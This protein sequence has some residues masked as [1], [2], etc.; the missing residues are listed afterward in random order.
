MMALSF[1]TYFKF[2][3]PNLQLK[4]LHTH[5][6][7]I[8]FRTHAFYFSTHGFRLGVRLDPKSL[9]TPIVATRACSDSAPSDIGSLTSSLSKSGDG[10]VALF[11]QM[12]GLDNDFLDREQAVVSLWKYS[13]GGKECIDAIMQ[14][15]GSVIL[16]INL[17]QSHSGSTCEAASGLL[18]MI[19][20]V[21]IYREFVADGGAIEAI[22]AL[23]SRS[24]LTPEEKEQSIGTLWNLS[25]DEKLR[26][27]IANS[28]LLPVLVKFLEDEDNKVKTA[29]GGVLANLALSCSN[30]KVM[31]EAGVIPKLAKFLKTYEKVL[32]V[33]R[34]EAINILSEEKELKVLRKEAKNALLE[35]A[36]DKYY[37]ILIVE[38]GLV[39]VPLVG[40]AAYK[41]FKPD[42]DSGLTWPDGTEIEKIYE[43]PAPYGASEVLLELDV[44]GKISVDDAKAKAMIGQSAQQSLA[45]AGV[46]EM[47]DEKVNQSESSSDSK[48]T[49]LEWID[50]IARLVLILG[51]EDESAIA[52]AAEAIADASIS[53]H[54]R[55]SFK[56]AG[57]IKPLLQLLDHHSDAVRLAAVDA[58]ERLSISGNVLEF[59]DNVDQF[60]ICSNTVCQKI[61]AEGGLPPL[62]DSL[63]N[64][65][66]SESFMEKTLN[67]LVRMLDP[68]KEVKSKFYDGPVNGSK[69]KREATRKTGSE[70]KVDEMHV[71]NSTSSFP[72]THA[73]DLWDSA[74]IACLV[75]FLKKS[76][77]NLQRKAA[78]ILECVILSGQSIDTI[79]S[80]D[81]ESGL[82]A[83]FQQKSLHDSEL[84]LDF[85]QPELRAL[86]VEEAGL[87]V[88]AASRLLTRLLDFDSFSS[89]IQNP[90]HFIS[91]LRKILRSSIPLPY[92]NWVASALRKLSS[93]SDGPF[94]SRENPI[95]LEVIRY[96]TIPRL[97]EQMESPSLELQEATVVE[98]YRTISEGGADSI[99]AVAAA[100]GIFPLVKLI[101][102]G[103]ERA[104]EAGLAI[105][106]DLSMDTEN[107]PAIIAAGAVPALRR[108][109]LSQEPQWTRALDLLRALPT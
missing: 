36:K 48:F 38:E 81:I 14:F 46:I 84:Q 18:R 92:K 10:S 94:I 45:R 83:V 65:E 29:S 32:K 64:S 5:L 17:L 104:V 11:V 40:S 87:A 33:P 4:K 19:S 68:S 70:V 76:S 101:E 16:I 79:I 28:D 98:L 80:A 49:V 42:S 39:L 47:D 2:K 54:M 66:V 96:E 30:H 103:T 100:G 6:E 15:S 51:L 75:E 105:L 37:R 31:V 27:K 3:P 13:Q 63:K 97:I 21:P 50:G 35:L 77:P 25:V 12:L 88:S 86:E 91:L 109:I 1:P 59:V 57:A 44:N 85:E 73:R 61:E 107:H 106:Y 7:F 53:E 58:L 71:L 24:S 56:E 74:A 43:G 20:S 99:G 60:L 108:I 102:E 67:I 9:S 93:L 89:T 69:K 82:D 23:L 26:E 78:S 8:S 22:T 72:T 90:S 55:T 41:S 95:Y 62:I 52:R 34:K